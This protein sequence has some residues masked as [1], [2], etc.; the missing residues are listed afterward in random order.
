MHRAGKLKELNKKAKT[1]FFSKSTSESEDDVPLKIRGKMR[2]TASDIHAPS[3]SCAYNP[4]NV[5]SSN[6]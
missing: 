3:N 5:A 2:N 6:A 4:N 1:F